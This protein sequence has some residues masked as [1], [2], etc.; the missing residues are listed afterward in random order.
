MVNYCFAVTYVHAH[1]DPNRED[2]L[3]LSKNAT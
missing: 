3:T 2:I 1:Q